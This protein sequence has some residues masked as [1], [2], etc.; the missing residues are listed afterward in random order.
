MVPNFVCCPAAASGCRPC[1][2]EASGCRLSLP[3]RQ[4]TKDFVDSENSGILIYGSRIRRQNPRQQVGAGS[5][6]RSSCGV[7]HLILSKRRI[8]RLQFMAEGFVLASAAASGCRPCRPGGSRWLSALP[9]RRQQVAV[10]P[11]DPAAASGCRPCRPR[12]SKWLSALPTPRQQVA[13][14]PADRQQVGAGPACP[15]SRLLNLWIS[16]KE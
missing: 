2:P 3:D 11:A 9:T 6:C 14:G 8:L 10:G 12:G 16:R 7:L 4:S 5:A 1:R 13:V 15:K